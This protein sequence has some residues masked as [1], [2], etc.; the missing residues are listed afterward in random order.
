MGEEEGRPYLPHSFP[1][2]PLG[3][4]ISIRCDLGEG[5]RSELPLI[6]TLAWTDLR[7]FYVGLHF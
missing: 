1:H 5:R 3:F 4:Q 2:H 7:D 6:L